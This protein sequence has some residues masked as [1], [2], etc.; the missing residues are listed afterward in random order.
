MKLKE[1]AALKMKEKK[2]NEALEI[3]N[4]CLKILDTNEIVEY[5]ALL[6]N[7]CVCYLNLK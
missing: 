3:Y 7:R 2:I 5:L 6:L 1:E 4:E